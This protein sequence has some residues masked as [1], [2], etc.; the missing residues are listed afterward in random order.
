MRRNGMAR[1]HGAPIGG[2]YDGGGAGGIL[3][4]AMGYANMGRGLYNGAAWL[5]DALGLTG[6]GA[7][8]AMGAADL[9]IPARST[10]MAWSHTMPDTA[11]YVAYTVPAGRPADC[12]NTSPTI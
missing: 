9:A 2:G 1:A 11:L 3:Q 12:P 10:P 7:G 5:G 6:A 4:Q 8:A